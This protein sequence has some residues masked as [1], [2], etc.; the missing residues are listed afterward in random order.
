MDHSEKS[1]LQHHRFISEQAPSEKPPATAH[2]TMYQHQQPQQSQQQQK[3]DQQHLEVLSSS[4]RRHSSPATPNWALKSNQSLPAVNIEPPTPLHG[5]AISSSTSSVPRLPHAEQKQ[6]QHHQQ[7]HQQNQQ[8]E[9]PSPPRKTIDPAPFPNPPSNYQRS[10]GVTPSSNSSS[11]TDLRRDSFKSSNSDPIPSSAGPNS[12][13]SDSSDTTTN[14]GDSKLKSDTLAS[15][16]REAATLAALKSPVGFSHYAQK[17]LVFLNYNSLN[18]IRPDLQYREPPVNRY[19]KLRQ[20]YLRAQKDK[21]EAG[22]GPIVGLGVSLDSKDGDGASGRSDGAVSS[23]GGSWTAN[24]DMVK[25][26]LPAGPGGAGA[27]GQ[28]GKTQQQQPAGQAGDQEEPVQSYS[29]TFQFLSQN[30]FSSGSLVG[31]TPAGRENVSGGEGKRGSGEQESQPQQ[32]QPQQNQQQQQQ[33]QQQNETGKPPASP[34]KQEH[35]STTTTP[36]TI[37]APQPKSSLSSQ[38]HASLLGSALASSGSSSPVTPVLGSTSSATSAS[39]LLG[40]GQQP[41][42]PVSALSQGLAIGRS[43]SQS[44][45]SL[46]GKEKSPTL[47]SMGAST[48]TGPGGVSGGFDSLAPQ[49]LRIHGL[50]LPGNVPALAPTVTTA[51]NT[52][53]EIVQPPGS[54]SIVSAQWKPFGGSG[55]GSNEMLV[56]S[57]HHQGGQQQQQQQ[58]QRKS[59]LIEGEFTLGEFGSGGRDGVT[60]STGAMAT[61]GVGLGHDGPSGPLSIPSF[62]HSQHSHGHGHQH[63]HQHHGHGHGVHVGHGH[64]PVSRPSG[65]VLSRRE[66]SSDTMDFEEEVDD[67]ILMKGKGT[68]VSGAMSGAQ[69]GGGAKSSGLD[70]D[71]RRDSDAT[72]VG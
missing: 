44:S 8:Q 65:L 64:V 22:E 17:D 19:Y 60:G 68:G 9:Q 47:V 2:P 39:P 11:P 3:H 26:P 21:E 69:Q 70:E 57:H 56:D 46:P 40:L 29:R 34:S 48:S 23:F 54:P 43:A 45:P 1:R 5:G 67:G 18:F 14:N 38:V 13:S 28:E 49:G 20:K 7:H 4:P 66:S 15:S 55:A 59:P 61:S 10:T 30:S 35:S 50:Q 51:A 63:Q 72:V 31:L 36:T 24:R 52:F 6:Q 62:G 42:R 27:G 12:A 32:Q 53:S 41:Q 16:R 25:E 37:F 33:Q 71:K 58:Q